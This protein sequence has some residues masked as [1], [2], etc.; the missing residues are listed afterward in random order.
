ANS[1][2]D[3]VKIDTVKP[4]TTIALSPASPDG[5]N[6]WDSAAPSFSLSA[7]DATSGVAATYY[8]L[9]GGTTHT[10]STDVPIPD[11]LHTVTYWSVD[12]AGNEETHHTTAAIKVATV[13]PSIS[14]THSADGSSGWNG[15]SPVT[16]TVTPSDATSGLA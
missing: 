10:Y 6:G 12:N 8:Q 9:D 11:G 7:S 14:L 5:S 16:V 2:S 1:A 15:S 13:T 3:T 4:A